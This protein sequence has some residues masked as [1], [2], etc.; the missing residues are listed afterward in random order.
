MTKMQW[1]EGPLSEALERFASH[2]EVLLGLDFDGTLAPLVD[3]PTASRMIDTARGALEAL[4][5]S[6]GVT[7]ALITGRAIDSIQVVGEP[8]PHWWL[9]GSHGVEVVSPTERASYST[10]DLVPEHLEAGFLEIVNRHP[11]T[12][13]EKKPF[14]VALHTRGL[15]PHA[16]RAAEDD[17]HLFLES[18]PGEGM[19][20]LG[21]GIVEFALKSGNKGD[22]IQALRSELGVERVFFA[23]DDR[24]DEDG[25]AVLHAHDVGVRV[26]EGET[27]ASHRVSDAHEV[28]EVLW[29][30][31]ALR[32]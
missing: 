21:H 26:G 4:T 27:K 14:G 15:E 24:T 16:A 19:T 3:D 29:H 30:L 11:G 17:A 9:V 32:S 25:F 22:G 13:F 8:L 7:I 31:Q 6:P 28:A 5:E 20:R 12:R 23:G 1:R 10:P 2:P 18:Y